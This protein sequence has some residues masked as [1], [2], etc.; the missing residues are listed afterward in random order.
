MKTVSKKNPGMRRALSWSLVAFSLLSLL[1]GLGVT[2][3]D[4]YLQ[5]KM[6]AMSRI[7]GWL[8][9]VALLASLCATPVGRIL[10]FVG[11]PAHVHAR[12]F[13]RALGISSACI[14]FI[15]AALALFGVLRVNVS[16]L[17]QWPHLRSAIEALAVL[18]ILLLTSFPGVRILRVHLWKEL[19]RL[20]YL[21][22]LLVLQHM[23]LAP[24]ASLRWILI[25]FGLT[26]TIGL[27]RFVPKT[28]DNRAPIL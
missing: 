24:F 20:A 28:S 16:L 27:L 25:C 2:Y 8:A 6:I 7:S 5:T 18:T 21:A 12:A 10:M 14:S 1:I 3:A 22:A 15:H 4:G 9:I 11:N 23:L 17:I 19:H 13:R 26:A